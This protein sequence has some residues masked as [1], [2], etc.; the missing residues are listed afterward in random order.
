M[1]KNVFSFTISCFFKKKLTFI[2]LNL[3]WFKELFNKIYKNKITFPKL[4]FPSTLINWNFASLSELFTFFQPAIQY[5]IKK[6][7]N[8][9]CS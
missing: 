1:L 7:V 5:S 9:I 6:F 4:P 2:D 3:I 8:W